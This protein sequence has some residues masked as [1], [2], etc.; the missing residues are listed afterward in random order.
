MIEQL[1]ADIA[2]YVATATRQTLQHVRDDLIPGYLSRLSILTSCAAVS[3]A[4]SGDTCMVDQVRSWK[5]AEGGQGS[6]SM[7]RVELAGHL[8][9]PRDNQRALTLGDPRNA[10]S[11]P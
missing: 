10:S 5:S 4:D 7:G 8:A 3:T 2:N 11:S 6:T 9:I 1:R